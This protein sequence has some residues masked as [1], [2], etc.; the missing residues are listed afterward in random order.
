MGPR[1]F[2]RVTSCPRRDQGLRLHFSTPRRLMLWERQPQETESRTQP[3]QA[4][5]SGTRLGAGDYLGTRVFNGAKGW[6]TKPLASGL[7]A[8][9]SSGGKAMRQKRGEG[10]RNSTATSDL[11]AWDSPIST[12]SPRSSSP[13]LSFRLGAH[14]PRGT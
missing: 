14:L 13:D 12:T 8:L 11:P 9:Q 3:I 7:R 6:V 1:S 4:K 10:A 2:S 5:G